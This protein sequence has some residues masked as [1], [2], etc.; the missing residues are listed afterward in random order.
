MNQDQQTNESATIPCSKGCGFFGGASTD[1]MC[2]KCFKEHHMRSG[3]NDVAKKME[4]LEQP[5]TTS[6][7]LTSSSMEMRVVTAAAQNMS[8]AAATMGDDAGQQSKRVKVDRSRCAECK[9]KVGLAAIECRCG[10]VYCGA[11]RMAEKHACCF[12]FKAHG[13]N[14]IEKSNERVVAEALAEKL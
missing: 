1:N 3:G 14:S 9:K 12:D 5:K 2:S 11:H 10:N 8:V 13:R 6:V 4:F 7:E